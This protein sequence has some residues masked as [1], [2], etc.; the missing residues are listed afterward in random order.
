MEPR[1]QK[2]ILTVQ[3]ISCL[4]QCSLTVA[5]PI[6]S[7]C[8]VE[9]AIIPSAILSTH[10]GSWSNFTF[11]D[12]TD[13]LP[14]I[15]EHWQS[16]GIKFDAIY[17]GYIGSA[18]QFDMINVMKKTLLRDGAPV[19]IDPAMADNGRLYT[20]FDKEYVKGMAEFVRDA[21]YLLPNITEAAL[22]TDTEYRES[23]GK[24]YIE[25]LVYGLVAKGVKNVI[26]TGVSFEPDKIGVCVYDGQIRYYFEDRLSYSMHGTGDVYSSVFTG[27][28]VGGQDIYSAAARA[29][30]FTRLA[31]MNTPKEHGYGVNFESL[32][33]KLSE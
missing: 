24:E 14:R 13:D 10:T 2:R 11:R 25:K 9:A 18:R 3:D 31:M 5:L 33:G 12:L 8:G 7:A 17:T 21:D 27:A 32:L 26:I 4:G 22:I 20:G 1:H 30:G 19:I 6:L 16:Y 15:T 28:L 29:A 23:Y